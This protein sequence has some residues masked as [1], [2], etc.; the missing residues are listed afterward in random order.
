MHPCVRPSVH[1]CPFF[2]MSKPKLCEAGSICEHL[3]LVVPSSP[4]ISGHYC[5]EGTKM[6][7]QIALESTDTWILEEEYE[8][9]LYNIA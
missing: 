2:G 9:G 7:S 8:Y 3:G 5:N 6:P 1:V 4:C